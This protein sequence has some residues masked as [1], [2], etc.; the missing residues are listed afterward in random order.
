MYDY[1]ELDDKNMRGTLRDWRKALRTPAT[2]RVGNTVRIQPQ[3]IYL[4]LLIG[5][6]LLLLSYY[7]WW[8]ANQVVSEHRWT[9]TLRQYNTTYPLTAPLVSSGEIVTFR[10]GIVS[11]LDKDSKSKTKPHEF[12]SYY[13]KGHLSYNRLKKYVSVTWD[14]QPPSILCSSYSQKGRGMELSE[15]IVY[16]GRLLAFDDRTG[17]VRTKTFSFLSFRNK[18]FI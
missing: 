10:I 18:S 17:M 9:T 16:D 8:T 12:I 2:Y 3:F 1:H 6:I 13:K 15:L 14:P 7:N 11:D 4:I 5:G